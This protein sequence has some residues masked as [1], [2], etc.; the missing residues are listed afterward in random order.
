[1]KNEDGILYLD[2]KTGNLMQTRITRFQ[3][4][5]AHEISRLIR[6]YILIQ[7]SGREGGAGGSGGEMS[8]TMQSERRGDGGRGHHVNGG[9]GMMREFE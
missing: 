5:H 7:K 6:Q 1:M 8:S 9:G 3:T 4:E 2:M